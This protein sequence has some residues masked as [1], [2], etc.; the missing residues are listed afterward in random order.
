MFYSFSRYLQICHNQETKV[1]LTKRNCIIVCVALWVISFLLAMPT[2]VGWGDMRVDVKGMLCV[3]D[4]THFGYIL[5]YVAVGISVPVASVLFAN[6]KIYKFVRAHELKVGNLHGSSQTD[7]AAAQE[8]KMSVRLAKTLAVIFFTYLVCWTPYSFLLIFDRNDEA[9]RSA[10][11]L[12]I[13]LAHLNSSINCLLYPLNNRDFRD[14]YKR[15]ANALF[16]FL[17]LPP[18]KIENE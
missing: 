5:F 17:G 3:V 14:G 18:F 2:H 1:W 7:Q 8:R 15:A 4:R 10:Y 6:F 9:S 13:L 11:L 12:S 16:K